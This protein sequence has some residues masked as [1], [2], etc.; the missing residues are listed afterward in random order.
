[1]KKILVVAMCAAMW[2]WEERDNGVRW[3]QRGG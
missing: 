1:M 3:F 2:L